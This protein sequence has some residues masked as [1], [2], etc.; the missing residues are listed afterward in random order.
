MTTNWM[1]GID[2]I[3]VICWM[4][5]INTKVSIVG[6]HHPPPP[7]CAR[8]IQ[9]YGWCTVY[10]SVGCSDGPLQR[11]WGHFFSHPLLTCHNALNTRTSPER[12]LL[13]YHTTRDAT[14]GSAFHMISYLIFIS[15][16]FHLKLWFCH[17]QGCQSSTRGVI[18]SMGK[19][20]CHDISCRMH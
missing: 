20:H 11:L 1:Y 12:S 6:I 18:E 2:K 9:L 5:P 13:Q 15:V 19:Q 3:E 7:P 17:Q 14:L 8:N 16:Y 4:W 10:H